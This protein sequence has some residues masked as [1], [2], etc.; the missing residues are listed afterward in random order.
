MAEKIKITGNVIEKHQATS[1]IRTVTI[2][3][4]KVVAGGITNQKREF[5][6]DLPQAYTLFEFI[7][8]KSILIKERTIDKVLV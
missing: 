6:I 7:S 5:N 2:I 1:R 4:S 3:N 8:F